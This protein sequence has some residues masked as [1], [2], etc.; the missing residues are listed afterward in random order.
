MEI[1]LKFEN[2]KATVCLLHMYVIENNR[3][4][5]I[6]YIHEINTFNSTLNY[7]T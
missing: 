2:A 1:S 7:M 3:R 5:K 4:T 6:I